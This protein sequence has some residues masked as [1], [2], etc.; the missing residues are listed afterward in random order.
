MADTNPYGA[1]P[2]R[3]VLLSDLP[4]HP[5]GAKVRF[6]GWQVLTTHHSHNHS[7]TPLPN[8][9]ETY[10]VASATLTLTHA[11]P[12]PTTVFAHVDITLVLQSVHN[13]DL[14]TGAWVNVIGYVAVPRSCD[15]GSTTAHIQA[16]TLWNAGENLQLAAYEQAVEARK[17]LDG[18][19]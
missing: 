8:S 10:A 4:H 6:L 12:P 18:G 13:R 3:L 5:I 7:L 11:Y 9:V 15:N 2:S 16:L 17:A 14:Q 1:P 19:G